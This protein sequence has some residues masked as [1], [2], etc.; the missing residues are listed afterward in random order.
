MQLAV[1]ECVD[2]NNRKELDKD[3]A[4][5]NTE[6]VEVLVSRNTKMLSVDMT[7]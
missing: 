7:K 6:H 5:L 3:L 2:C 4:Q 1:P